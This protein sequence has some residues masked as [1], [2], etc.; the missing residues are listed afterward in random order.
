MN[1]S[2]LTKNPSEMAGCPL[3]RTPQT[4]LAGGGVRVVGLNELGRLSLQEL[5]DGDD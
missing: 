4:D 3:D 2:K 1:H 5:L